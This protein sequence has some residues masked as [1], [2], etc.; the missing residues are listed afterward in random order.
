MSCCV[1]SGDTICPECIRCEFRPLSDVAIA[2][3]HKRVVYGPMRSFD[4]PVSLR[5]VRQNA[6]VVDVVLLC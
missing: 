3:F 4:D 5:V 2:G 6:D 1:A